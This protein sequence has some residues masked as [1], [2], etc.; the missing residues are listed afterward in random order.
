[1]KKRQKRPAKLAESDER[2]LR[3]KKAVLTATHALLTEGGF[4]G[5]SVDQVAKRSGVAKTTIYRHWPSRTALLLEACST[6][7]ARPQAPDTGSFYSDLEMMLL[8]VASKL[9]AA[10]WAT[11]LPS[12]IDAAERDAEL[13]ELQKRQHAEMRGAFRTIVERAQ[14]KGEVAAK[15]DYTEVIASALGPLFYRRWFSREPL[16]ERFVRGV[17]ERAVRAAKE[18]S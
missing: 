4:S 17:V 14:K 15:V 13:A 2:V 6:L 1:M 3:S 18:D 8:F 12:I 9:R 10:A 11:V 16:D 5:V 7:S